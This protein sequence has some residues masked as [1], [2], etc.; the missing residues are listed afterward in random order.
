MVCSFPF[1]VFPV[2]CPSVAAFDSPGG[3]HGICIADNRVPAF[4]S[5]LDLFTLP[6]DLTY[7]GSAN[8]DLTALAEFDPEE[9]GFQSSFSKLGASEAAS[10]QGSDPTGGV[11]D[12]KVFASREIGRRSKE[13][14]GVVSLR[15]FCAQLC[16][17]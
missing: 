5:L 16:L 3:V 2:Y 14:R 10:G 7:N 17:G 13:K 12:A 6:Q 11:G 8:E 9:A 15:A 4:L 1:R